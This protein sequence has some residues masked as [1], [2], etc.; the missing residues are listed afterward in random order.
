MDLRSGQPAYMEQVARAFEALRHGVNRLDV[1]YAASPLAVRPAH[2]LPYPL[3]DPDRQDQASMQCATLCMYMS[4]A[5]LVMQWLK[6]G[7]ICRWSEVQHL[8]DV[9]S[10]LYLARDPET[11]TAKVIKYVTKYGTEVHQVLADAGLAPVL[12]ST[13]QLKGNF[14]QVI[15]AIAFISAISSMC[16]D[17]FFT[18]LYNETDQQAQYKTHFWLV[19]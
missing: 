3:T 17:T 8:V 4:L 2:S 11:E 14:I 16:T 10:F 7:I 5:L 13:V 15:Y 1:E 6:L 18:C 12:Y 19:A 9:N